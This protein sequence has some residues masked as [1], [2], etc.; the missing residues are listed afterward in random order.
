MKI[1]I[2]ID[3]GGTFT[4]AV[5]YDFETK[6][7]LAKGK[8]LTTHSC[9]QDG[10][11]AALD[12]LPEEYIRSAEV[13]ALSTT[14]ATNACLEDKGSRCKLVIFGLNDRI[15]ENNHIDEKYG[16]PMDS[17]I[18]VETNGSA[19][20]LR[21]DVPDWAK[22]FSEKGDW[23]SDADVLACSELYSSNNGA[24]AEKAFRQA[25]LDRF[26]IYTVCAHE[27][28]KE[29][30][31]IARGATAMLNARLLPIINDFIGSILADLKKRD[32]HAP[33]AV[34]RSDGSR[35]NAEAT[36]NRP[37]ETI[38]SGPSASVL[39]GKGFYSGDNYLTVDMG[40]TTTDVSVVIGGQPAPAR[41]GIR[42]GN[43]RT[44]VKGIFAAPFA[45]GGDTQV[46]FDYRTSSLKLG[47]RRVEP[48]CQAAVKWPEI[49][50]M[51][52]RIV[53][54]RK[55]H[56]NQFPLHEI[57]YL[58]H[59]P[60][61]PE[62]YSEDEQRLIRELKTGP[63]ILEDLEERAG[64][65]IYHFSTE[66]LESEEIIMRCG[67]TPTDFMHIKGDYTA[68]DREASVLGARF[69]LASLD[70]FDNENELLALC[71]EVYE[72]VEERMYV[73]LVHILLR[74]LYPE[75]FGSEIDPQLD[76][77]IRR[78][79]EDRCGARNPILHQF[80]GSQMALVGIGAPIHVFLPAVAEA[81]G[82]ECILPEHHDV[83]NAIG[84]LQAEIHSVVRLEVTQLHAED[85]LVYVAHLPG[86]SRRCESMDEAIRLLEKAAAEEAV[87]E[88]RARGAEG[89][90]TPEVRTGLLTTIA[91]NTGG[92]VTLG[93]V[94][95]AR[96]KAK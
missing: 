47:V 46:C 76:F 6:T 29:I 79:W 14:L 30:N 51:L 39:A 40:G 26:G 9:L 33:V 27:I 17:V 87:K 90:L 69:L 37:V 78:A 63:L 43:W 44:T 93:A 65:D 15:I 23:L 89:S 53:N 8:A 83:A 32:C 70:R 12:T 38:L 13:V 57:L 45:L 35:M 34:I 11:G 25:V 36:L 7:V 77:L 94:V 18:A 82:A 4:D 66:R 31:V 54:V 22:L 3:T 74:H 84:A 21:A 48:L 95:E 81:L 10:I 49:K 80:F 42:L 16:I 68:Y 20:G 41:G 88:A 92:S 2:G 5:A 28:T 52:S 86:G 58:L 50:D 56:I 96:V 61:R 64:L 73:N 59:E 1:G 19:D 62:L 71:R 72:A 91:G 55:K 24:P 75:R 67:L 85:G 60:D